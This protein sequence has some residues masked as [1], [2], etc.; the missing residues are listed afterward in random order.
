MLQTLKTAQNE[1]LGAA[2]SNF[3]KAMMRAATN[4]EITNMGKGA[5]DQFQVSLQSFVA[6]F[7][8]L[9]TRLE[10]EVRR[11]IAKVNNEILLHASSSKGNPTALDTCTVLQFLKR[12]A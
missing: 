4:A 12:S 3:R 1:A 2:K 7:E 9:V 8:P 10:A 5:P 11:M 6:E